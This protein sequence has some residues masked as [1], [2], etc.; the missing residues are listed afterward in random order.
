MKYYSQL[1]RKIIVTVVLVVTVLATQAGADDIQ[2]TVATDKSIYSIGEDIT[3]SV[4]AYNPGA[5]SVTL[6]FPSSLQASYIMD[7]V[8]DW[9]EGGYFFLTVITEVTLPPGTYHT[10]EQEHDWEYTLG[11]DTFGYD[12]SV[13]THS[14]MGVL[15]AYDGLPHISYSYSSDPVQF[16]IAEW[17]LCLGDANRDGLVSAGDYAS[18]QANFGNIGNP[19]IPG[20]ANLDGVVSAGDYA[21]VQG[22]IYAPVLPTPEPATL[23]LL[24]L[25]GLVFFK[26][27]SAR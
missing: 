22:E 24:A 18:V 15:D 4:T 23:S 14:V 21:S 7:D 11:P 8:Y 5:K 19:G 13:G 12:L 1:L 16:E 26:K 27:R 6:T 25:G 17:V 3:V 10:W 20:D 2:L 9:I